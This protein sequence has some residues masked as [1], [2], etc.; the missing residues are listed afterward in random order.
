ML[1]VGVFRL[2]LCLCCT[3]QLDVDGGSF[4]VVNAAAVIGTT[5]PLPLANELF[6]EMA[7]AVFE[8]EASLIAQHGLSRVP[9]T[10]CAVNRNACFR[11]SRGPGAGSTAPK[12]SK[13]F[14]FMLKTV[15]KSISGLRGGR[16][17]DSNAP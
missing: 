11:S 1:V 13:V 8:L 14:A 10:H 15:W 16:S 7:G 12:G 4:T 17:G 6:P 3:V 2:S 9:S 5:I